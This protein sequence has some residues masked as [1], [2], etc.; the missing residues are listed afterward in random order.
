VTEKHPK[1]RRRRLL[2][3]SLRTL[4]V[5]VLLVS[6][7]L[8]RLAVRRERVRR[9]WEAAKA[10]ENVG[11]RVEDEEPE[12]PAPAWFRELLGDDFFFLKVLSVHLDH[13][14]VTDAGLEDLQELS[15]LRY[16]SLS[17]TQITPKGVKKLQEA[18][19]DCEIV[20]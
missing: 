20:Y 13:T 7:G 19:P 15:G 11:G 9:Q 3:F 2:Q 12:T 10:I 14:P 18:L 4:L 16:L 8:S 1:R 6:I 17:W 5:H